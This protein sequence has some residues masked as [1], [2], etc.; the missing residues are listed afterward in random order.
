MNHFSTQRPRTQLTQPMREYKRCFKKAPHFALPRE[1]STL[2]P[3]SA[4]THLQEL[5]SR[6]DVYDAD[7][8]VCYPCGNHW[9]VGHKRKNQ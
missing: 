9:H 7:R 4:V 8:L 3:A 6:P 2:P 1:S 5:L